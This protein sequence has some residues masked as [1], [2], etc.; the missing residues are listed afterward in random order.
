MKRAMLW[1]FAVFALVALTA[2]SACS[3][4]DKGANGM[5]KIE[6][7]VSAIGKLFC[8]WQAPDGADEGTEYRVAIVLKDGGAA[9]EFT[10]RE[11]CEFLFDYIAH[12]LQQQDETDIGFF[13]KVEALNNGAVFAEGVSDTLAL[14]GLIP[15]SGE[16]IAGEDVALGD[17]LSFTYSGSG[18]VI[19]A[20]FGF[21]VYKAL[22]G[23]DFEFSFYSHENGRHFEGEATLSPGEW[24]ELLA[25][26]SGLPIEG[27]S[28]DDPGLQMLDGSDR[29]MKLSWLDMA[30]E[31]SYS[32]LKPDENAR[33]AIEAWLIEKAM[34]A[35]E[36]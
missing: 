5:Q 25:L 34:K 6:V 13:V 36:G 17:I 4:C 24:D 12:Y 31:D 11:T 33:Q 2:L 20:N 23:A 21:Y 19:D 15:A 27:E 14:T 8:S 26:I 32:E 29:Q 7:E 30:P 16:R 22:Y 3:S 18:D 10:T 35:G 28:F 9:A 1:V